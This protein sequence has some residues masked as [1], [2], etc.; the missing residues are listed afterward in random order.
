MNKKD[1]AAQF[2]VWSLNPRRMR[3]EWQRRSAYHSLSNNCKAERGIGNRRMQGLKSYQYISRP[4]LADVLFKGEGQN[5]W[6]GMHLLVGMT[7]RGV[8]IDARGWARLILRE[9]G[10]RL[11]I[12][13]V[14]D[15]TFQSIHI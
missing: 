15:R 6:L 2:L 7:A 10:Q 8:V 11:L 9:G 14:M 13:V 1:M 3:G 5:D 12:A 4:F